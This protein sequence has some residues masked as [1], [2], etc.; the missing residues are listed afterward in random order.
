MHN[1]PL[2]KQ[3]TYLI[4]KNKQE[5]INKKN[6]KRANRIKKAL[7]QIEKKKS[8]YE[9]EAEET[10]FEMS[11]DVPEIRNKIIENSPI[12]ENYLETTKMDNQWD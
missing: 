2:S 5:Q 1:K 6:K 3:E 8:G 4:I 9:L 7:K 12:M 11:I 10:D